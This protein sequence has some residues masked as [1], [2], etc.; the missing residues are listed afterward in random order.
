MEDWDPH[1]R[2]LRGDV[3]GAGTSFYIRALG[4][5]GEAEDLE[6]VGERREAV[7]AADFIAKLP[8]FFAVELDHFSTR[9]ADQIVVAHSASNYLVVGL[10]VVKEYLFENSGILK[11][12]KSTINCCPGDAVGD[13]FQLR[14]QLIRLKKTV[15]AQ[16]GVENHRPFRGEFQLVIVQIAPENSTDRLIGQNLALGLGRKLLFLD[17]GK[18]VRPLRHTTNVDSTGE[19]SKPL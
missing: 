6:T 18:N 5:R 8:E 11:V 3:L 17:A 19:L 16:G 12:G 10:L 9:H 15:L 2:R 14:H 1:D 4:L 7:L 13:I